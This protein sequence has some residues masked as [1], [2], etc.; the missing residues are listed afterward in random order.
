MER[1][2]TGVTRT[3]ETTGEYL[4]GP[5]RKEYP[6]SAAVLSKTLRCPGTRAP[7]KVG[8]KYN[9]CDNSQ[10]KISETVS[11]RDRKSTRLN[12]SHLGISYAVFC[13]KKKQITMQRLKR[14]GPSIGH[15]RMCNRLTSE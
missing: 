5:T 7:P 11:P 9:C 3:L 4:R 12:S 8:S 6:V 1:P 10:V 14:P 2:L 15:A 13:L